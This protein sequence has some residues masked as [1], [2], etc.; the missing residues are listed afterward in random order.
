[1]NVKDCVAIATITLLGAA[2]LGCIYAA[3]VA[4][5]VSIVAAIVFGF[6]AA[7]LGSFTVA[8]ITAWFDRDSTDARTYFSTILQYFCVAAVATQQ[9]LLS[10]VRGLAEGIGH[11]V[12]E[13]CNGRIPFFR[14]S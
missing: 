12:E 10:L 3:A 11:V 2:T 6:T 8:A 1:M 7:A 5:S 4:S 9:I 13:T 14:C